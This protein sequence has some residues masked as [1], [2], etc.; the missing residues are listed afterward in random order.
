MY[1]A[2]HLVC[3]PETES[4]RAGFWSWGGGLPGGVLI[5]RAWVRPAV[6]GAVSGVVLVDLTGRGPTPG[7]R[8]RLGSSSGGLLSRGQCS[9]TQN[10]DI[11]L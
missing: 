8:N 1:N 10:T 11:A 9:G 2:A 6:P 3:F 7:Q 4:R 5:G